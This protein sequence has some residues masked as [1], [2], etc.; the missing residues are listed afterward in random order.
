MELKQPARALEEFEAS[1]NAA[2]D[3]LRGLDGAA[4]AAETAGKPDKARAYYAQIVTLTRE[5]D[6]ERP[7]VQRTKSFLGP[8]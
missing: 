1:L 4:H 8:R 3:R 7:D 6:S 5:A 2:R